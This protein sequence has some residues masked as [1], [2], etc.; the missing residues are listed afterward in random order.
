MKMQKP[1]S[2]DAVKLSLNSNHLKCYIQMDSKSENL[3]ESLPGAWETK[4]VTLEDGVLQK[5]TYNELRGNLM[6]YEHNHIKRYKKDDKNKIVA[7]TVETT[8][9]VN[10]NRDE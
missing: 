8:R 6:A 5:M 1:F 4:V 10:E 7:L 2:R 3:L 9:E